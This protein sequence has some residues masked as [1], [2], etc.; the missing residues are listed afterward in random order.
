MIE[1]ATNWKVNEKATIML[2]THSDEYIVGITSSN[3]PP[4][5]PT[6]DDVKSDNETRNDLRNAWQEEV[7]GVS[8]G[9]YVSQ[10]QHMIASASRHAP[11]LKSSSKTLLRSDT[12][13]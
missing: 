2:H 9:A 10:A 5:Y 11:V 7:S 13:Q 8:Q 12:E 3:E 4:T 1:T 6:F